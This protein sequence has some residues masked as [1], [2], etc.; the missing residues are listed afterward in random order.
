M[1]YAKSLTALITPLVVTLLMPL[2]INEF[3]S[4]A[5]IIEAIIVAVTTALMVFLVPNKK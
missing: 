4:L 1:T 3:S 5:Q 2:G